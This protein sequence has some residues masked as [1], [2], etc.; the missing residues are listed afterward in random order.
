M[1]RRRYIKFFK[2]FTYAQRVLQCTGA[3]TLNSPYFPYDDRPV[4]KF[5]HDLVKMWSSPMERS[6]DGKHE[7]MTV[8]RLIVNG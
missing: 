8:A 1:Y 4:E 5:N 6:V 7:N 3:G 2:P